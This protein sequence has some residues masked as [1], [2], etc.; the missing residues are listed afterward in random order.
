M[1]NPMPDMP[2]PPQPLP[3]ELWGEEWRF[4]SIPA[5]DLWEMFG[6]RPIPV[7]SMP[8]RLNPVNLGIASNAFIPGVIIY[9]GRQSM[10]L[11]F[12]LQGQNPQ[13]VIYQETEKNL[14]GGLLLTGADTQRWVV[15][16]F[17]DQAIA[18]AG[19]RYYQ[20]QQEAKG[21]H[22]LLVQP[23]DSDV[24]YSGLWILQAKV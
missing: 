6:D 14:A 22:F 21:L 24:T 2:A 8:D 5:G 16:T 19:Q 20:R 18:T 11:T 7:L 12:W 15:M 4:A 9:G 3:D 1:A 10:Q 13:A 23:D 17:H